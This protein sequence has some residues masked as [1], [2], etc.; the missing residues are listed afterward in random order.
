MRHFVPCL[1]VA[2]LAVTGL[3]QQTGDAN[4]DYIVNGA[5]SFGSSFVVSSAVAPGALTQ[6][7]N[8]QDSFAPAVWVTSPSG[9]IGAFT[10]S[11]NSVDINFADPGFAIVAFG[12]QPGLLGSLFYTNGQGDMSLGLATSAALIGSTHYSAF[13]HLTPTSSDGFYISQT[14]QMSFVANPCGTGAFALALTDDST[15]LQP[16]GF[17]Y[18]YYGVS[19][20][21][22]FVNSNGNISFAAGHTT[23]TESLAGFLGGQPKICQYWDDFNPG[24]GG[25]VNFFTDNATLARVCFENVPEFATSNQNTFVVDFDIGGTIAMQYLSMASV[26]GIVGLSPGANIDPVG[27]PIDLSLGGNVFGGTQ[28]PYEL[29]VGGNDLVGLTITWQL[30]ATGTPVIQF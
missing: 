11:V 8:T 25:V 9:F 14:H 17:T 3:A 1:V 23:F 6:T 22:C 26:D 21:D 27:V 20:T 29:F 24:A 15:S 30:D 10:T 7:Y 5:G 19:Y 28:A 18:V 16:L 4:R 2:A 12:G 13:A